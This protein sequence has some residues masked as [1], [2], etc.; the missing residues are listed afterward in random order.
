MS[1]QAPQALQCFFYGQSLLTS[2]TSCWELDSLTN[3]RHLKEKNCFV[4]L[5]LSILPVIN[6]SPWV[7][8]SSNTDCTSSFTF[9]RRSNEHKCCFLTP[10]HT[11]FIKQMCSGSVL[12]FSGRTLLAF[13]SIPTRW[14]QSHLKL[15]HWW[16]ISLLLSISHL[17]STLH[18]PWPSDTLWSEQTWLDYSD[19]GECFQ[20][21]LLW[22][23]WAF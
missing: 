11:S 3:A 19:S 9:I 6:P 10:K 22:S 13:A 20:V 1:H 16:Y 5:L 23:F 12:N 2:A 14:R 15:P 8:F 4:Y 21:C 17:L 18:F 7:V